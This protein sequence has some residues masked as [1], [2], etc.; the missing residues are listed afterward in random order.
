MVIMVNLCMVGCKKGTLCNCT[1]KILQYFI[2]QL[3]CVLCM[4]NAKLQIVIHK[5]YKSCYTKLPYTL[6]SI[7]TFL[8]VSTAGV[9][10]IERT[11]HHWAVNYGN[12]VPF[13]DLALFV[14]C[15]KRSC[16]WSEVQLQQVCLVLQKCFTKEIGLNVGCIVDCHHC[17]SCMS[18]CH[19]ETGIKE[20][21]RFVNR[22]IY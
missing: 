16:F 22:C 12:Q 2:L 5:N 9:L 18:H 6:D 13:T 3:Q 1:T 14:S 10:I 8:C 4:Y 17:R 7:A 21:N 11:C 15:M 19:F 20:Q